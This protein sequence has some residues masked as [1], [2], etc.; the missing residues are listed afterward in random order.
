MPQEC[1]TRQ[2]RKGSKS[3][4]YVT[5]CWWIAAYP[6]M[7]PCVT[8]R[9]VCVSDEESDTRFCGTPSGVEKIGGDFVIVDAA[10]GGSTLVLVELKRWRRSGGI[11]RNL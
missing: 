11:Q 3:R 6:R 2:K 7:V 9:N 4:S 10:M 1:K 8:R 5:A